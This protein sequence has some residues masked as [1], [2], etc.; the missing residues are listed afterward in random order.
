MWQTVERK[1]RFIAQVMRGRLDVREIE[2]IGEAAL[3]YS[4]VKALATGNPMLLEKADADGELTRLE[5]AERAHHRNTDA[6]L[7]KV[8]G[9]SARIA[10]RE[11][12]AAAAAGAAVSRRRDTRGDHFTM[13]VAGTRHTRRQD[14]GEHLKALIAEQCD[15]LARSGQRRLDRAPG[16]LGGFGITLEATRLMAATSVVIAL[17]G[18]PNSELRMTPDEVS[19]SDPGKLIVRMEARLAG[20]E[21][22][23]G[24]A[25]AEIERLAG[26]SD[27]AREDIARPFPQVDQLAAARDRVQKIDEQMSA[28]AAARPGPGASDSP[29]RDWAA[30]A[31]KDPGDPRWLAAAAAHD[32]AAAASDG[33]VTVP[34]RP[35]PPQ[36]PAQAAGLDFPIGVPVTAPAV[37][38][39]QP[40]ARAAQQPVRGP[41]PGV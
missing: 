18:A 17:A 39:S 33:S 4:E 31:I 28:A 36:S 3:S 7:H 1:A 13:T 25:L 20:L 41:A 40:P 8:T 27:R 24:K 16:E 2:D 14:A 5:R 34:A 29:L 6:L 11:A 19:A 30:D 10:E 9:N 38:T 26:E 23:K 32:A 12:E 21:A 35:Q 22:Y 37:A 15:S